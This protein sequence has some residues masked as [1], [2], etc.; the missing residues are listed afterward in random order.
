MPII[1]ENKGV[2]AERTNR[3]PL[4]ENVQAIQYSSLENLLS[5]KAEPRQQHNLDDWEHH[6]R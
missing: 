3:Y 5:A 2:V 4:I 1:S 6:I